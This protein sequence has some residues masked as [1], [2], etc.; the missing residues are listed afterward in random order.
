MAK[1]QTG[2][3]RQRW[4]VVLASTQHQNGLENKVWSSPLSPP[5]DAD[6]TRISAMG[7]TKCYQVA[8]NERVE[9]EMGTSILTKLIQFGTL[10][11]KGSTFDLLVYFLGLLGTLLPQELMKMRTEIEK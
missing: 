3:G 7:E 5:H 11:Y 8:E 9:M 10:V 1:I 2:G 4:L 6:Q